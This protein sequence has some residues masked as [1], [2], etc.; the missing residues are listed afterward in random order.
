VVVIGIM[1]LLH[2][3]PLL[4]HSQLAQKLLLLQVV[5]ADTLV[6]L[7]LVVCCTTLINHLQQQATL[8]LW[9]VVEI[10][11]VTLLQLQHKEAT[12]NLAH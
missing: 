6:V 7:A 12:L 5:V 1:H 8:Q 9:V 3:E 10:L 4:Q 2:Q 11:E